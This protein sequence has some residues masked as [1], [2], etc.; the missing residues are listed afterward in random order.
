[1]PVEGSTSS[2]EL[3]VPPLEGAGKRAQLESHLRDGVRSGRLRPDARLPSS[4]TL[5]AELG[6]SRRL[7]V[8]AYE[9]LVA[10]GYLVARHG[11]G[12]RVAAR[13]M[14]SSPASASAPAPAGDDRPRIDLFPGSPDLGLFPRRAWARALRE[15]LT[16]LPD[17]RLGVQSPEGARELRE[18]L[19]EHL[20]RVRGAQADPQR[21]VVTTG[22]QHGLRLV[23]ALIRQR[24]GRRVA[25]EDPG[26][27]MVA[28]GIEAAG[29]EVAC[30]PLDA[31]GL[32]VGALAATEADAVV[33]TP[34]HAMPTG[35]VL[36]P[37]RRAALIA[38]AQERDALII[39]DDYDAEFRY[40]REPLGALQGLAPE[41]VV[42]VGSVSKTLAPA[43]R[44]GWL[45]LPADLATHAALA[46]GLA[47][48]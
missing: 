25:V 48:G 28:W 19:A 47:D 36:S 10:E 42:L 20:G 7:V 39:E 40:D 46:R 5:A 2:P 23:C 34:A 13:A 45:L 8:D 31:H 37:G 32:D 27:P 21:I 44:V 30:V 3:L 16:V 38:W 35:V 33:V 18:A 41:R 4:R 17:H 15:T 6:V 26:Y 1:M 29:L 14:V 43:L 24:G 9:Q 12:T 22:F 11:S